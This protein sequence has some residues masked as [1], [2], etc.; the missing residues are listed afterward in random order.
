MPNCLVTGGSK[1]D[2]AP[3]AV[4]LLNVAKTQHWIDHVVVYHDWDI[5][6]TANADAIDFARGVYLIPIRG[7]QTQFQ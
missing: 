2:T 5:G 7:K 3:I 6:K 1:N 4:L